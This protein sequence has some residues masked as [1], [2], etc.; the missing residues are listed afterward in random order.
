MHLFTS[1][2][3]LAAY[4]LVYSLV[5]ACATA[6]TKPAASPVVSYASADSMAEIVRG[7]ATAP[8]DEL[9]SP[10]ELELPTRV[11]LFPILTAADWRGPGP[12][13]FLPPALTA[14]VNFLKGSESFTL[15]TELMPAP[16]G[17]LGIEALREMAAFYK[18]RYLLLYRQ[19]VNTT[20]W[21]KGLEESQ[22]NALSG[23]PIH[24]YGYLEASMFDV[25]TGLLL[26]TVRVPVSKYGVARER[27]KEEKLVMLSQI[28]VEEASYALAAKIDLTVSQYAHAVKV[29]NER[30]LAKHS[31]PEPAI[32]TIATP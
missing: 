7:A 27:R 32:Q 28:A 31:S 26:F 18:L 14:L 10:I 19:V 20:V 21:K 24:A 5:G 23:K 30:R 9:E 4:A 22:T 8:L 25:K 13:F 3:L 29:E 1:R 15:V 6:P 11:G 17:A 12:D 16:S 2:G